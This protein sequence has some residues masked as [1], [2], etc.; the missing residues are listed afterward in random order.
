MNEPAHRA[1]HVAIVGRANV[2]KSTLLNWLVGQKI[3]ITSRKPQTT[4]QRI[5][6]ILTREDAQLVFVDTPGYQ[7]PR[8]T[9]LNRLMNRSVISGAQDVE[10]VL[11]V[12]EALKLDKRDLELYRALPLRQPV[13]LVVVINKV[14]R[15]RNRNLL[16]PFMQSVH[17][18]FNSAAIVPVSA[19]KNSGRDELVNAIVALLPAGPRLFDEDEITHSSERF[20]AAE[21]IREKL[22]RTLGDELPYAMAVDIARFETRGRLR[23]IHA[24]IIVDKASQKPI[25]IGRNGEKLKTIASLAREDME[26][27]FGGKVFLEIWVKVKSGW[28]DD[29]RALK[30][31]GYGAAEG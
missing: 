20:L 29:E 10:V 8:N 22:F 4:R 27:L 11:L 30:R 1:G 7:A 21:L 12:V 17:E 5:T 24:E 15:V 18:R 14:D 31:M 2:G 3:S 23:H 25:V 6:G 16:L 9:T 13:A 19:L 28:A 26:Q